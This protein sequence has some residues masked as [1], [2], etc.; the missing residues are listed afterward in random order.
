M[1]R[2]FHAVF[3]PLALLGL[4]VAG[5][6]TS[7]PY[8]RMYSPRKSYYVAPPEKQGKSAEEIIKATEAP[9]PGADGGA[10]VL[11]QP[12]ALPGVVPPPPGETPPPG[13]PLTDPLAP[14]PAPAPAAPPL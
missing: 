4:G 8:T 10:P 14:A 11:P 3:L 7:T 9:L 6:Q 12:P 13:V 5:C 1:P 2:S